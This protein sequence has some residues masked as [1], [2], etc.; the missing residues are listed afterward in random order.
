V[1]EAQHESVLVLQLESRDV[2]FKVEEREGVAVLEVACV[3]QDGH[4]DAAEALRLMAAEIDRI[5]DNN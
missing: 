2:T 5:A 4:Q 3:G 1:P